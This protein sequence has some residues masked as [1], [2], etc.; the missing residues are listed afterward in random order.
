MTLDIINK[1]PEEAL[2]HIKARKLLIKY[3]GKQ[4]GCFEGENNNIS[5]EKMS[6]IKDTAEKTFINLIARNTIILLVENQLRDLNILANR[7]EKT[8]D[9]IKEETK[10]DSSK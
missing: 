9:E 3:L 7:E 2:L 10:K 1:T 6:D 4:L 8:D 5:L